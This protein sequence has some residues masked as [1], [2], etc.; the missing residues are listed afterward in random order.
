MAFV[1]HYMYLKKI[2]IKYLN[3]L[4]WKLADWLLKWQISC[5]TCWINILF[6]NY[7]LISYWKCV[8]RNEFRLWA[9]GSALNSLSTY[10]MR[11]WPVHA[12]QPCSYQVI[13]PVSQNNPSDLFS[14]LSKS[15][16]GS[17][18]IIGGIVPALC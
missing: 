11:H 12:S 17:T 18:R 9:H 3:F 7:I 5:H 14:T 16:R 4:L 13:R 2:H 8:K 1:V 10:G 15:Y 6:L